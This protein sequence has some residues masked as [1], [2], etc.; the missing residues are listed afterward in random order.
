MN[1]NTTLT[2]RSTPASGANQLL[3]RTGLFIEKGDALR[4][5]SATT[6]T[7]MVSGFAVFIVG[8]LVLIGW[9]FGISELKGGGSSFSSMKPI[10]AVSFLLSAATLIFSSQ[11][12]AGKWA[13]LRYAIAVT[14]LFVAVASI[15]QF[16]FQLNLT[17]GDHLIANGWAIEATLPMSVITACAFLLFSIAMLLSWQG[18]MNN[19]LFVAVTIVGLMVSLL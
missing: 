9:V 5:L 4:H 11:G 6:A 18:R 3:Q 13:H 15:V 12:T 16:T 19:A 2:A 14:V 7:A 10:T 8:V 1:E 17:L